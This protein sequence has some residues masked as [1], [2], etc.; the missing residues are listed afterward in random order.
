VDVVAIIALVGALLLGSGP[1]AFV[2]VLLLVVA[3]R[4]VT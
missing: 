2:V 4:T 1:L 3:G